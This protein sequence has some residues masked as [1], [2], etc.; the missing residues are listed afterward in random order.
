MRLQI[1]RLERCWL[2]ATDRGICSIAFGDSSEELIVDLQAKF[3]RAELKQMDRELEYAVTAIVAGMKEH[4]GAIS[5]PMDVRATAFQQR[6]WRELQTIPR[7]ETRT[8]SEV[9]EAIGSP[10]SVRA[11]AGACAANP[12]A[13]VVPCHRVV[14]KDGSLTG[15]RW[16][17]ERKRWLL[18]NEKAG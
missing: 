4:A 12:V 6:V 9:A 18:E 7:G 10:Q 5:L 1:L 17:V 2:G 3:P 11:V 16:G 13:V 15:Y 14:G 8:Y